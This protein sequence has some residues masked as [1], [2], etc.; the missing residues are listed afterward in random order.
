MKKIFESFATAVLK[1]SKNETNS[2]GVP[3]KGEMRYYM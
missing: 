1:M 2:Q 3:M